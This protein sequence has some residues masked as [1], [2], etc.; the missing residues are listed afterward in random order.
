MQQLFRAGA[1]TLTEGS[2]LERVSRQAPALLDPSIGY[3]GLL[4]SQHGRQ[5]LSSIWKE[6]ATA[7]APFPIVIHTPT[8]R[9]GR[10]RMA[11]ARRPKSQPE[12]TAV[13]LLRDLVPEAIIA[14]L[15]GPQ[16]DCYTPSEAPGRQAAREYHA[17]QVERLVEADCDFLLAATLPALGEAL[18]VADAFAETD[19]A[20]VLSF[21]LRSDG[22]LLDGTPLTEAIAEIDGRERLPAGY[23]INCTHP[24]V[25]AAGMKEAREV[26]PAV[27]ARVIGFQANTSPRD[28]SEFDAL[29]SLDTMRPEDFAMSLAILKSEFGLSI[30]GGCC[31]TRA[32]HIRALAMALA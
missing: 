23:W 16:G 25:F 28:P 22:C 27:A 8:W 2:V 14:G 11:K 29:T 32:A 12:E 18:G 9:C 21:V 26:T 10:E 4:D 7:A 20:Y 19:L 31:G 13:N 24:E 17:W 6:Y 15:V 30:L 5:M 1:V 3:A